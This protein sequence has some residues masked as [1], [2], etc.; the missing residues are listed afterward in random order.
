VAHPA[1]IGAA[2]ALLESLGQPFDGLGERAGQLLDGGQGLVGAGRRP[3]GRARFLG[4]LAVGVVPTS[5][6]ISV[7]RSLAQRSDTTSW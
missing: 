7:S 1:V 6:V 5:L 4:E 2:G 3:A